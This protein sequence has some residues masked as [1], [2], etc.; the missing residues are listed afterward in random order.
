MTDD[1]HNL[2]ITLHDGTELTF[3]GVED[4]KTDND[5]FMLRCLNG[6][7]HGFS[8]FDVVRWSFTPLS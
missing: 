2:S 7:Q 6:R 3:C 1:L 5:F 8:K 4:L